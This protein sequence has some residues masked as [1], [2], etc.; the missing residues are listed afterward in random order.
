MENQH[1]IKEIEE[2]LE[3][4]DNFLTLI[5]NTHN[6]NSIDENYYNRDLQHSYFSQIQK[7]NVLFTIHSAS[8]FKIQADNKKISRY[9]NSLKG[10]KSASSSKRFRSNCE[11]LNEY[12]FKFIRRDNIDKNMLKY[13]RKYIKSNTSY[14]KNDFLY[15]FATN[16]YNPPFVSFERDVSFKSINYSYL[17]WLFKIMNFLKS[18]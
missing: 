17:K 14:Y 3:V 15:K 10:N 2:N 6:E 5:C 4:L 18:L 1:K 9:N 7:A 8:D 16:N 13:I 11:K 12:K